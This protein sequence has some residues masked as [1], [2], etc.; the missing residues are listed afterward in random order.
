MPSTTLPLSSLPEPLRQPETEELAQWLVARSVSLKLAYLGSIRTKTP[1]GQPGWA[2]DF[3]HRLDFLSDQHNAR[4]GCR[5]QN[6]RHP[7]TMMSKRREWG[8]RLE[9]VGLN[10]IDSVRQAAKPV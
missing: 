10:M 1:V 4:Y 9:W 8:E 2:S 7:A 5:R 6:Y 3:V